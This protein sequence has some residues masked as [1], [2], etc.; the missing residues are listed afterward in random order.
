[1]DYPSTVQPGPEPEPPPNPRSDVAVVPA[2]PPVGAPASSLR[3]GAPQREEGLPLPVK[4]S[5]RSSRRVAATKFSEK[6]YALVQPPLSQHQP[7][8]A[9]CASLPITAAA[10]SAPRLGAPLH[11]MRLR[12][13]FNGIV[14]TLLNK[15][16]TTRVPEDLAAELAAGPAANTLWPRPAIASGLGVVPTATG[17]ETTQKKKKIRI[18]HQRSAA[19]GVESA[20]VSPSSSA[21]IMTPSTPRTTGP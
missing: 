12:K 17:V 14:E 1:M 3:L 15:C 13:R 4:P 6:L 7:I 2:P 20:D 5:I 8:A 11:S 21:T 19:T 10:A 9:E 16:P 18:R